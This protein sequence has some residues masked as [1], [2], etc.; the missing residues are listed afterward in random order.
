MNRGVTASLLATV[1]L[2]SIASPA[3]AAIGH[4]DVAHHEDGAPCPDG[5]S[6][7]QDGCDDGCGCLCCPGHVVFL[8]ALVRPDSIRSEIAV[9]VTVTRV[10]LIPFDLV[11]ALY[12]PP[13]S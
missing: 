5:G 13:R 9:A 10:E 1:M 4:F 8:A 6:G 7:D 3:L 11:R 12:R 2:L